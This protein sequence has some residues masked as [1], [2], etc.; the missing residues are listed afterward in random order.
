MYEICKLLI[1]RYI[2]FKNDSSTRMNIS[3][4][5][6]TESAIKSLPINQIIRDLILFEQRRFTASMA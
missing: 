5:L 2:F 6:S 1:V 4:I 3:A